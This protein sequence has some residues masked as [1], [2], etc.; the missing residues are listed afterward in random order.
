MT[1]ST[2]RCASV[3]DAR[4]R[5]KVACRGCSGLS[6]IRIRSA[7]SH[8]SLPLMRTTP[9]PPRPAGVAIATMVS[10]G[11]NMPLAVSGHTCPA[12]LDRSAPGRDDHGLHERIADAFGTDGGI[13]GDGQM[14][15]ATLVRIQRTHF[16]RRAAAASLLRDEFRHLANLRIL[17]SAETI[18]VDDDAVVVAQLPAECRRHEML[19]GLQAFTAATNQRTT[20]LSLQVDPRGFRRLFD[21]GP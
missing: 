18:A 7:T 13:L 6:R 11:E 16:L 14:H 8:A 20:V 21:C 10:S 19:E 12:T 1:S 17:V 15:N 3:S 5:A 9:R 2:G 4:T